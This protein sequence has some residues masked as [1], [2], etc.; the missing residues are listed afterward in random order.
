MSV[1]RWFAA[2]AVGVLWMFRLMGKW[3]EKTGTR[4]AQWWLPP[5]SYQD[6]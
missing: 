1:K 5:E 4:E 3:L 2:P 6:D